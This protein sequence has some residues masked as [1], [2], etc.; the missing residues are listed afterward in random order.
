MKFIHSWRFLYLISSR[1]M[2]IGSEVDNVAGK[3]TR[4]KL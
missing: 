1:Y 2:A 4:K 3:R